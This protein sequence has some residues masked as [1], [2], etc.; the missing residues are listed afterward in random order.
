MLLKIAILIIIIYTVNYVLKKKKELIDKKKQKIVRVNGGR[1]VTQNNDIF[2]ILF[3]IE[4]YYNFNQQSYIDLLKYT[5]LFL[6]IIDIIKID[7]RYSTNLYTNLRDIKMEIINTLI[8][9]QINLPNEFNINDVINDYC[10]ILDKNLQDVYKIH[11]DYIQQ[12]GLDY[13]M[14]LINL[15]TPQGYNLD[16]SVVDNQRNTY[17]SRF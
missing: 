5:E 3:K 16:K 15:H 14:K 4:S 9:F 10:E 2:D 13:T 7:P 11:E 1:R 12:N 8:S 17:F 6:E